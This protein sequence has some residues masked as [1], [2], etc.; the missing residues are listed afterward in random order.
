MMQSGEAQRSLSFWHFST[1]FPI[2]N[3][4]TRTFLTQR[5]EETATKNFDNTGHLDDLKADRSQYSC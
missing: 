2:V 1:V 3:V 4:P 5:K